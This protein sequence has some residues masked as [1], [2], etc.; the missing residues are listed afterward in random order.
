MELRAVVVDDEPI[1]RSGL[2]TL[3]RREP[4]IAVVRECESRQEAI[5][6]L[7][8]ERPH[9]VFLDVQLS[10][11]TGFEVAE[12][13]QSPS[14]QVVF[15]T[16]FDRHAV[17]AFRT[18]ALDYI[19]K[20]VD[21]ERL[22]A[23][24]ARVRERLQLLDAAVARDRARAPLAFSDGER[25]LLFSV[26]ELTWIEGA[27]DYAQVHARGRTWLVSDTLDGLERRLPA[28]PFF[29]VHRSAIVN[30]GHVTA[31][32]RV[33]RHRHA[34]VLRDGTVVSVSAAR[35]GMLRDWLADL[36]TR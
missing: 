19:V 5:A 27:D 17:E 9:V 33:S 28:P 7:H 31:I 23:S 1:A 18:S 24:I 11:G 2:A 8:R 30:V 14:T 16:A 22:R 25:S 3:L 34:A 32:K 35:R 10:P 6:A 36:S 15:V 21:P 4:S 26:D 29:R 12:Q 20:P 13:M